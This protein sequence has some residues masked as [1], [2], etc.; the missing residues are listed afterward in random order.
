MKKFKSLPAAATLILAT[1]GGLSVSTG[2]SANGM[3]I[4]PFDRTGAASIELSNFLLASSLL[5]QYVGLGGMTGMDG[6]PSRGPE[7]NAAVGGPCNNT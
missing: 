6:V 4:D 1:V 5:C 3:T 2:A 7:A